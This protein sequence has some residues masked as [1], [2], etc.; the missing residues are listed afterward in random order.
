[1]HGS[2]CPVHSHLVASANQPKCGLSLWGNHFSFWNDALRESPLIY[3]LIKGYIFIDLEINLHVQDVNSAFFCF[4]HWF[5][6]E[7]LHIPGTAGFHRDVLLMCVFAWL[8]VDQNVWIC[9][10]LEMLFHSV[11]F[12]T[13]LGKTL[14]LIDWR[15][16][17]CGSQKPC[18]G[19]KSDLN[20][21]HKCCGH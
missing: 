5:S 2:A 4:Y 17:G 11:L 9:P 15:V 6:V 7:S 13:V 18:V 10:W 8:T 16:V 14:S 1:M 12:I 19:T 21:D 20:F 3:A